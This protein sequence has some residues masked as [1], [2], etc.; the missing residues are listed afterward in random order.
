MADLYHFSTENTD[1]Y[2]TDAKRSIVYALQ[3]YEPAAVSRERWDRT[4]EDQTIY[5][6]GPED[7][8]PFDQFK[9]YNPS[10]VLT[11]TIR[12]SVTTDIELFGKVLTASYEGRK[13]TCQLQLQAITNNIRG[14]LPTHRY[15]PGCNWA[16]YDGDC[17]LDKNNFNVTFPAAAATF[18]DD[19]T[20]QHPSIAS[21]P[22][23]TFNSG[24]VENGQ[25]RLFIVRHESDTIKV[26]NP[27]NI[28]AALNIVVYQGC[29]KRRNTC[30]TKFNNE[31][32]FG[33]YP[34]V[35]EK[36]P[37]TEGF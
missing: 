3:T 15:S 19:F 10:N 9:K 34:F 26:M 21:E 27:F 23:K 30:I 22:D 8:A 1:W 18:P 16:L 25:E 28:I 11:L 36:N 20:I 29:N 4:I 33:G 6:N 31:I 17:T 12:N 13:G 2:I 7:L 32:N 5:I 24:H 35:P 37:V 14:D